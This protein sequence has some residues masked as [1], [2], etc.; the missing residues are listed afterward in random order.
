MTTCEVHWRPSGGRGEFEFVPADSLMDRDVHVDFDQLG[1]R[2]DAEVSGRLAQGKPRLRKR[3]ANNRRKLHLP[4]LV[5]AVAAL[6]EPA[7]S[8]QH[9]LA[10][11]LENKAFVIDQMDF[12]VIEDD[13]ITAV[14]APLRVSILHSDFQVQLDDRLRA[15]AEDVANIAEIRARSPDLADAVEAHAGEIAKGINSSELRKTADR[16]IG[17]KSELFGLTNAG[18]AHRLVEAE[19]LP[20]V[21]AEE[22]AGREGR[23]LTRIHVYKERDRGLVKRAKDYYRRMNGGKLVCEACGTVPVDVY[24]EAGERTIEAHHKVPIE[25]LQP[26]SET[27]TSDLAMVCAD[28]HR[29]IHSRK[30][31]LTIQEVRDLI[32]AHAP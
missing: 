16:L 1:I 25:E 4:Q 3:E 6:P 23:L 20:E 32:A 21:E 8:D 14:L 24:G 15:I 28:C 17:L 26:D 31:C 29:V 13:G 7:R 30:P 22:T 2:I 5:M 19:A 12:D 10:F 18:S 27:T 9:A 11:P